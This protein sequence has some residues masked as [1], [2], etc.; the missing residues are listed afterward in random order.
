VKFASF[1]PP[2][3][4]SGF[5][6]SA[7]RL[8]QTVHLDTIGEVAATH[9]AAECLTEIIKEMLRVSVDKVGLLVKGR[10]L[11]LEKSDMESKCNYTI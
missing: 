5:V 3:L 11:C 6:V 7:F 8:H 9:R 2:L 10:T 1:S 4:S